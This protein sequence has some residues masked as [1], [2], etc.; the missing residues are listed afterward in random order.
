MYKIKVNTSYVF[1]VSKEDSELL[2]TVETAHNQYHIL[3]DHKPITAEIL[4]A[5]FNNKLYTVKVNNSTYEVDIYDALDLQ[6]EE[7]G[8]EIGASK[9]VSDIKA[10]MPGLILEISVKAGQE[11]NE[12]D[13][14]LILEAMKMENVL[15]SPR[16]GI[17]KSIEV[18]QGQTVDKNSLL[19]EFE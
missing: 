14:L 11:V 15:K 1:N 19:I 8:F 16:H 3:Q 7:L 10:P 4:S 17:I 6:I 2:D 18:K 13:D 9:Q 5:D 12:N